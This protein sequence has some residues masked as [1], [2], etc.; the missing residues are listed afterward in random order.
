MPIAIKLLLSVAEDGG[1]VRTL[2]TIPL[3]PRTTIILIK[4]ILSILTN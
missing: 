3:S 4:T 1:M 2:P